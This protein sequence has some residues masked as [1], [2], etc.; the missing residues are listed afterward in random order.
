[1]SNQ[2][3]SAQDEGKYSLFM[4][5]VYVS[6]L[7]VGTGTADLVLFLI[8]YFSNFNLSENKSAKKRRANNAP[9]RCQSWSLAG[10]TNAF[11]TM[12]VFIYDGDKCDRSYGQF[13]CDQGIL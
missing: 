11:Y 9:R 13:E 12:P 8:L 1:M 5:F 10:R 4:G 7:I 2:S 6:N 3:P